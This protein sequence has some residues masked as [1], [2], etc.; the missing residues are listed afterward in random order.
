MFTSSRISNRSSILPTPCKNS[1]FKP[2][3]L[4]GASSIWEPSIRNTSVTE[5][6]SSPATVPAIST[7]MILLSR[8]ISLA[9]TLKRLRRSNTGIISPRKLMTPRM[10]SGVWGRRVISLGLMISFTWLISMPNSSVASVNTTNCFS[11]VCFFP[12]ACANDRTLPSLEII[13]LLYYNRTICAAP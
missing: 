8:S 4:R 12:V 6:T 1:A 13:G 2:A 3:M 7:T 11:L 10:N 5:S 9:S